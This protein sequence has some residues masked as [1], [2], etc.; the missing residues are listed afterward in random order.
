VSACYSAVD[1]LGA[2]AL[3]VLPGSAIATLALQSARKKLGL[4]ERPGS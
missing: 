3:A 4:G 2:V 1:V